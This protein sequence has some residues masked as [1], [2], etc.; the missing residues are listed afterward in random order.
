MTDY[1]VCGKKSIIMSVRNK[2]LVATSSA[3][4][5]YRAL[6]VTWYSCNLVFLWVFLWRFGVLIRHCK[7]SSFHEKSKAH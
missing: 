1:G 2:L 4:S 6:E 3:K 7:Q 5:E